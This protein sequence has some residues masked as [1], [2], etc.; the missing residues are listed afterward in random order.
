MTTITKQSQKWLP[1]L[2]HS[3]WRQ[4]PNTTKYLSIFNLNILSA[5]LLVIF[6]SHL[7][8]GHFEKFEKCYHASTVQDRDET[9]TKHQIIVLYFL[10]QNT[11]CT[12]NFL[13]I[14]Q[15]IYK[16]RFVITVSDILF[17]TKIWKKFF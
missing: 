14:F 8:C 10:I 7:G 17:T 12:R 9:K 15:K 16:K 5:M 1:Q 11:L 6:V 3:K 2:Y 4:N 13:Y